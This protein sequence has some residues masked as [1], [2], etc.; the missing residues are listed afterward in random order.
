[1]TSP[2]YIPGPFVIP[3]ACEVQLVWN[4]ANSKEAHNVLHAEFDF[5]TVI[6]SGLCDAILGGI[7][8]D[9]RTTAYLPFLAATTALA[10]IRIRSMDTALQ[11]QFESTIN[12]VSGT[13]V[14]GAVPEQ[15]ALVCSL[16]AAFTGRSGRGR[17]YLTGFD[18]VAVGGSGRATTALITAATGFVQAV[19]DALFPNGLHLAIATR[20]HSAYT[21]PA[22][23]AIVPATTNTS[24]LVQS[25]KVENDVFDSQRRRA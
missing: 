22:T 7:N 23:G 5:G 9:T 24:T 18:P 12:G 11:P 20:G 6:D 19:S 16:K 17:V 2:G 15:V 10:A 8:V 21:S 13:G 25:L 4:L 14:L 1:M 3:G